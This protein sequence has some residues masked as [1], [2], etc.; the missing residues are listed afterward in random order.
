[1]STLND[2]LKNN[3]K[4][5]FIEGHCQD[6]PDQVSIL[7]SMASFNNVKNILEIGF[8]AGHSAEV[9]LSANKNA[10]VVSIDIGHHSYG[11]H[12]K[13]FIDQMYPDRHD[14][15]LSDSTEFL[16]SYEPEFTF[17]LILID[18]SSK[19]SD[20]KADLLNCKHLASKNTI[21]IMDDV[22]RTPQYKS[23][24]NEGPTEVWTTA[25]R[26]KVIKE[27]SRIEFGNGRGMS[28][29]RYIFV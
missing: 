17:D 16:P 12:G 9:F 25:V 14:L 23:V 21:V 8:N 2:Y 5:D 10:R 1:M 18:G 22:V 13:S 20:C 6:V 3:A 15:Y 19:L 27:I 29:G 7:K 11:E 26:E 28:W 24:H 4:I